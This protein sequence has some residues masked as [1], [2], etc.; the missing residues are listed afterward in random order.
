MSKLYP[1]S[2]VD[3]LGIVAGLLERMVA[4]E[5]ERR[6]YRDQWGETY[7]NRIDLKAGKSI[8]KLDFIDRK[9]QNLPAG[10]IVDVPG[11]PV[12]RVIL[13]NEGNVDDS[14]LGL[15]GFTTKSDMYI[16]EDGD[17]GT[18]LKPGESFEIE[19]PENTISRINLVSP[20]YD[21]RVRVTL[22]V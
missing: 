20:Y 12:R 8:I 9:H 6:Q 10:E 14:T 2:A 22:I 4:M 18:M 13:Y 1:Y 3:A 19:S 16:R 11:I 17:A 15:I 21:T 5:E 7:P